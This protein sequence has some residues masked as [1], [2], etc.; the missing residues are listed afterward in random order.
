MRRPTRLTNR[1]S[2]PFLATALLVLAC[3]CGYLATKGE[4][5][6]GTENLPSQGIGPWVKYDAVCADEKPV[7]PGA[8]PDLSL[9][10]V[11]LGR[12]IGHLMTEPSAVLEPDGTITVFYED[13]TSTRSEIRRAR[14]TIGPE[15]NCRP[16]LVTVLEDGTVFTPSSGGFETGRVGAPSVVR[17]GGTLSGLA[18][19]LDATYVIAYTGGE[20][21]GIGLARSEERRGGKEGRARWV[22]DH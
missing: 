17:G 5:S 8:S 22:P 2:A 18:S 12:T 10:P 7:P 15:D 4:E 14:V 3:G 16:A 11:I 20:G 19:G 1:A 13:R 6:R 21:G 9:Q